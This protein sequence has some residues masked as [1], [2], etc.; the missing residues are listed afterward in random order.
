[1]LSAPRGAD[2]RACLA[3]GGACYGE[4]VKFSA[5]IENGQIIPDESV[6]LFDGKAVEV[7]VPD[8]IEDEMTA[9]EQEELDAAL[10]EAEAEIERGEYVNAREF[11]LTLFAK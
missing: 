11:A 4:Q 10:D 6:E 2:E 5:H 8:D 7:L 1:M 9:E 3:V